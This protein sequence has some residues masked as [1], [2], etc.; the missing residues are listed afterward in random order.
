[1]IDSIVVVSAIGA[2][3][4]RAWNMN[5]EH[6][7]Y[8]WIRRFHEDEVPFA[9]VLLYDHLEPSE[10]SVEVKP[11]T[12]KEHNQSTVEHANIENK[13]AKYGI[14]EWT[15]RFLKALFQARDT[16]SVCL[17]VLYHDWR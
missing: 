8:Q 2:D 1:M 12:H 16:A 17:V 10:R 14:E 4:D 7:T 6:Q 5:R 15:N 9:R 3:P 13:L 11:V